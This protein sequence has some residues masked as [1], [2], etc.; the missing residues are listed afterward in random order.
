MI[1]PSLAASFVAVLAFVDQRL[2]TPTKPTDSRLGKV[3]ARLTQ[4]ESDLSA[5]AISVGMNPEKNQ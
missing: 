2:R 3:E 1:W 5:I 4:I